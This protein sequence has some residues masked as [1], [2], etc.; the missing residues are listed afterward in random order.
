[1]IITGIINRQPITSDAP[2]SF[3]SSSASSNCFSASVSW[4]V[5]NEEETGNMLPTQ[6][7]WQPEKVNRPIVFHQF[8]V[9]AMTQSEEII[10]NN[11]SKINRRKIKYW[12][13][14]KKLK[15][16]KSFLLHFNC[17]KPTSLSD[18]LRGHWM[19]C[20]YWTIKEIFQFHVR[21]R[22]V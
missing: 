2:M 3:E 14:F 5:P 18:F 10:S 16:I 6:Y 9:I 11:P 4:S 1:M 22:S 12:E 15:Q 21:F 19:C 20:W 8:L 17:A 7:P 13:I